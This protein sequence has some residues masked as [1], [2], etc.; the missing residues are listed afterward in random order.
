MAL[1]VVVASLV[2]GGVAIEPE[3]LTGRGSFGVVS[4][5]GRIGGAVAAIVAAETRV[6]VPALRIT[7]PP[8]TWVPFGWVDA[9]LEQIVPDSRGFG[10]LPRSALSK[11]PLLVILPRPRAARYLAQAVSDKCGDVGVEIS[12]ASQFA[13]GRNM[14][15]AANPRNVLLIRDDDGV[16]TR[17]ASLE[18]WFA[19]VG[20]RVAEM[21]VKGIARSL[22]VVSAL[23]EARTRG[24]RRPASPEFDDLRGE[25]PW[26][27]GT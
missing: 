24:A 22:A 19:R 25:D 3:E 17:D 20:A 7:A 23:L 27:A 4:K 9:V 12:G 16:P 14:R 6:A 11:E 2:D 1:A 13:H 8:E 18:R 15:F 21:R 5:G 26:L 10:E